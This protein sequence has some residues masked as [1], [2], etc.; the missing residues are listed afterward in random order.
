MLHPVNYIDLFDR[1]YPVQ[2]LSGLTDDN[3][4]SVEELNKRFAIIKA[5]QLNTHSAVNAVY[6]AQADGSHFKDFI[7]PFW[8]V[9]YTKKY[10]IGKT[11]ASA[12]RYVRGYDPAGINLE[13]PEARTV[14]YA[15]DCGSSLLTNEMEVLVFID[16]LLVKKSDYDVH[17][18]QGGFAVYVKESKVKLGLLARI[19][20]MRK[21]NQRGISF[22]RIPDGKIAVADEP[23]MDGTSVAHV[24]F[25]LRDL[26]YVHDVR[27]YT[28]MAKKVGDNYYRPANPEQYS[29]RVLPGYD[30]VFVGLTDELSL[31]G[32]FEFVLV[33]TAE[34]WSKEISGSIDQETPVWCIDLVD[35][36]GMPL[37]VFTAN[38]V[39]IWIKGRKAIAN[40]DYW[41]EFGS[42]YYPD[43]PPRIVFADIYYGS[44]VFIYTMS[45]APFLKDACIEMETDVL[46]GQDSI[47]RFD[48]RKRKIRL[49]EN[50]GL[51]FS[52]GH[53]EL[54]GDGIETVADNLAIHFDNLRDATEFNYRARF[55]FSPEM[56]DSAHRHTEIP[57]VLE[58]FART[59]GTLRKDAFHDGSWYT[60]EF[61]EDGNEYA[62]SEVLD[63]RE[64]AYTHTKPGASDFRDCRP[65]D[66]CKGSSCSNGVIDTSHWDLVEIHRQNHPSVP[67]PT[68][69][70]PA[71]NRRD[72]PAMY[73]YLRDGRK[74][75]AIDTK[76]D[77]FEF[78][79][80]RQD[81]NI[82]LDFRNKDFGPTA[83]VT[84]DFRDPNHIYT[85]TLPYTSDHFVGALN[86]NGDFREDG[87]V[88]MT[89]DLEAWKRN[90]RGDIVLDG[91][92]LV[93]W[94]T[95]ENN[96]YD[97]RGEPGSI[98]PPLPTIQDFTTMLTPD[99]DARE[100]KVPQRVEL[101]YW[102]RDSEGTIVL[103]GREQVYRN[104]PSNVPYDMR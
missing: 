85:V 38:D 17:P 31:I 56:L 7:T 72:F 19:I 34:F 66:K 81:G 82:V 73:F 13:F 67:V 39:D 9:A 1:T 99:G 68:N 25:D 101:A 95:D 5:N 50:V 30:S 70:L 60:G 3:Q 90:E 6:A 23:L 12:M 48:P 61:R 20:V 104:D 46:P 80:W 2:H 32:S 26:G 22:H 14:L 41:V 47:V 64:G 75:V 91:R 76:A 15:N 58:R 29:I 36:H 52:H 18:S 62:S 28:L 65:E 40:K 69:V 92:D 35:E 49:I 97:M 78:A 8:E 100:G 96:V 71:R 21:F 98:E 55:V 74:P 79:P 103:D 93:H 43:I 54:A 102:H 4:I 89:P 42:I 33:N 45:G 57:T 51:V 27:Y 53:L 84:L 24:T 88:I 86:P 11:E 83:Q 94:N 63:F 10:T 44:D 87:T 37:P 59:V 77:P 16:G